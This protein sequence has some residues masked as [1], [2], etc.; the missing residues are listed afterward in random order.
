MTGQNSDTMGEMTS[1]FV[2]RAAALRATYLSDKKF[3]ASVERATKDPRAPRGT[4]VILRELVASLL[5][6]RQTSITS[7][8]AMDFFHAVVPTSYC[9]WVL[10]DKYWREQVERVRLRLDRAQIKVPLARV[11][12]GPTALE[13]LI[14]NL[15]IPS[16][17]ALPTAG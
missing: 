1:I 4:I 7:N 3:R 6:D 14:T 8:D 11:L 12:S 16:A 15:R 2:D 13:D 9:D 10:L 5:R 17:V